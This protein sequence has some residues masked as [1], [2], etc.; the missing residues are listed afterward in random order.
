MKKKRRA[1]SMDCSHSH[2]SAKED[3]TEE[4]VPP[5]MVDAEADKE[6]AGVNIENPTKN[7]D[8]KKK[9]KDKKRKVEDDKVADDD[10]ENEES[11]KPNFYADSKSDE[12]KFASLPLSEKTQS[13]INALNFTRMTQIQNMAIPPLLAGKDMIA[14]AKTGSVRFQ[15]RT[16]W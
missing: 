11:E 8:K 12:G 16:L 15:K 2:I 6:D 1:E 3:E 14:S 7:K 13:G 5:V 10:V 9:G 4:G